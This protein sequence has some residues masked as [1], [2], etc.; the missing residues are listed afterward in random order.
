MEGLVRTKNDAPDL[1][2][3]HLAELGLEFIREFKFYQD[4]KWRAD[5]YL[6][7]HSVLI[8]VDGSVWANG[9]HN[10]GAGFVADMEKTNYAAMLGFKVLRCPTEQVLKGEAKAWIAKWL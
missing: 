5:F 6:P 3:V 2:A 4:R 1:L 9:R 10:R 8:E 7:E